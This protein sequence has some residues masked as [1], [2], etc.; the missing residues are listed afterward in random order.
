MTVLSFDSRANPNAEQTRRTFVQPSMH[1]I[2]IIGSSGAGKSTFARQLG[3]I[4]GIEV[5][6][7]DKIY[8]RPNW[9]EMPKDQWRKTVAHLLAG[10]TW[11]MDGNYGG[12]MEMRL[13]ACDTVIFLDLPRL[14][15]TWRIIKRIVEYRDGVRPDIGE[16][17][18]ERFDWEF[19]RWTWNYPKRSKPAVEERL[20]KLDGTKRIYRLRSKVAIEKFLQE[21]NAGGSPQ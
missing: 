3:E 19:L 2:L 4:T 11:I 1:R 8:W 9:V 16:G 18:R 17:C 14:I 10:D 21:I 12:T 15:C 5:V 13:A 20:A 6:H 7:L